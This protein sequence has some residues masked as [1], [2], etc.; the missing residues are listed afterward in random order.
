MRTAV[1]LALAMSM[2]LVL[3]VTAWG[4]WPRALQCHENFGVVTCTR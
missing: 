3:A 4:I 1:V 2:V